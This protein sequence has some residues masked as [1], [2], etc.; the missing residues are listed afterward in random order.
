MAGWVAAG[1]ASGDIAGDGSNA[2]SPEGGK[3]GKKGKIGKGAGG[4]N[5][6]DSYNE[7]GASKEDNIGDDGEEPNRE[8]TKKRKKKKKGVDRAEGKNNG[9]RGHGNKV[10]ADVDASS[11]ADGKDQKDAPEVTP[12]AGSASGGATSDHSPV[13][14]LAKNTPVSSGKKNKRKSEELVTPR[15]ET[16]EKAKEGGVKSDEAHLPVSGVVGKG[17]REAQGANGTSSVPGQ[18]PLPSPARKKRKKKRE[19]GQDDGKGDIGVGLGSVGGDSGT[20]AEVVSEPARSAVEEGSP[21]ASDIE[22]GEV[23]VHKST[24][25]VFIGKR[26]WARGCA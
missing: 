5:Q 4:E 13:K 6:V 19:S 2:G 16:P 17:K 14:L 15:A 20:S 1:I 24:K 7:E 10:G 12:A 3:D 11:T 18:S 26:V 22:R 25:V 21:S 8:K 9:E 23:G